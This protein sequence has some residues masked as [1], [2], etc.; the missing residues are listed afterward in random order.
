MPGHKLGKGIPAEFLKNLAMLDLTE[1]P[2]TDNLHFPEGAINEAQKLAAKA[3]E[4][5]RTFFLVNGSTCGIHALIMTAC[6]PGDKLIVGRDC[7]RSVING[8]MLAGVEPVYIKPEFD[9]RFS[10]TTVISPSEL[11]RTLKE[12]PDCAG[13]LITR[14][15]Y[16]G[17]CSDL[18]KIIEIVHRFDKLIAVDEA[19]GAHLKFN[20]KFPESSMQLGADI[21][22]QSAHKTLP[23]FTQGA[24][25]HV[26]SGKIDLE[27]L[28]YNLSSLQT[29]SPSYV[30]MSFLDIARALMETEGE[31]LL[32]A[33][34][35]NVSLLEAGICNPGLLLLSMDKTQDYELDKSRLVINVAG[36]G[37]TGFEAERLLRE[38]ENIQVEMSDM[39]NIVCISTIADLRE[40]FEKL[41][42]ALN[43]LSPEREKRVLRD[44]RYDDCLFISKQ[45][46]GLKDILHSKSTK[47]RLVKAAGRVSRGM[48][49]PY[50][51]GIPVICPGEIISGDAVAYICRI[52]DSGGKVNGIGEDMEVDIII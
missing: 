43:R 7:H 28:R 46:V 14:P 42:I 39:N 48:I 35:Q 47:V 44:S 40:D 9:S 34:L 3:F 29:T 12:N 24:Y 11:E 16:Y 19:H 10:I 30:I 21:C 23:A 41:C 36:L 4:A 38:K 8:M 25:L 51:P 33:L 5:E 20:G 52:L 22:V 1:I 15:N 18:E 27:K 26:K 32:D 17:I 49:T 6:K 31:R 2:G 45:A 37:R 50:P 13:V